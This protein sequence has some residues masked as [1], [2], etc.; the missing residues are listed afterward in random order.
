MFFDSQLASKYQIKHINITRQI[1]TNCCGIMIEAEE[2]R[3]CKFNDR[4]L[5]AV[6]H[7]TIKQE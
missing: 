5:P 3:Q 1:N 6:Q 2:D 4:I 7:A